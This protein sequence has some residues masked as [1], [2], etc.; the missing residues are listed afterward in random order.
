MKRLGN[1][2]RDVVKAD[3]GVQAI[4]DGTRY[5]RGQHETQK[6]LY[7]AD[8][9]AN[10]KTLWHRIDEQKAREYSEQLC[11]A[12]NSGTWRH[13]EPRY[14]RQFCRNRAHSRGKWRDLYIPCLD[15]HIVAHMVMNASMEAFTRGMHPHCCGSVPGRGIKHVNRT[16]K[17]WFIGDKEC[18]YFVKLDI[19][20]FFDNIDRNTLVRVLESKIKDKHVLSV[21]CQIIDS[22]PIPCPVGYY[23]SPW[24]AN[25]YLEKFDW[26]V[27]QELYKVRRGKRIKYV[28]HYLRYVDD[29]LLVGTSKNDLKKAIHEIKRFLREERGL[30]L[31]DSWEIKAI[32]KHEIVDGEW[33]MK[34]GT[35]WCDIGGY[36]FSKDAT[37][38]RDGIYLSTKRLAKQMGKQ[39]RFTVHQ[40][41]SINSRV[42]W[43]SHC[44]SKGFIR[45]EIEP[46]V[47]INVTRGIISNVDKIRKR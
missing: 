29:I 23:T 45:N 24:F 14:R 16:V 22:A 4:I 25:L 9:I 31:K 46:H 3:N 35:Y 42:G 21:F 34:T 37:V 2:W 44:N 33:K 30:E 11:A 36:K 12:L 8:A 39:R 38:L 13:K 47:D 32:G 27:E 20:H 40:C 5:K 1:L 43:A 17:K 18:R 26:F 19:R 7:S 28:R 10:D 6:L 41:M 15:D